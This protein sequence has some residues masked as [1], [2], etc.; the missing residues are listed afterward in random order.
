[1]G[2]RG[3]VLVAAGGVVAVVAAYEI[4]TSYVAYTDDSYVRTDLVAVA[5][6]V[7]GRIVALQVHDNE[8]VKK[9]DLLFSIDP[10]PFR[11]VIAQKQAEIGE[12]MAQVAADGQAIDVAQDRHAAAVSAVGFARDTQRRMATLN[13]S[14]YMARQNLD[15][16]NDTLKRAQDAVSAAE[17]SIAQAR[18]VATMHQATLARAQA[19]M[20]TAQWQLSR[21]EVVSPTD[22]I[23]NNLTI[24]IGDTA[25]INQPLIGI[26]DAHAWRIVAN[27]KQYY[28][29]DL[30]AGERV[31][32]WLDSQPWHLHRGHIASIGR[33]ISRDPETAKLLPYVAPTTDWIRLQR[34]FPVTILLDEPPPDMKFFM[35]ADARTVIFP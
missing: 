6:E 17:A 7:T 34:R 26:L 31:W 10:V 5:P 21:T 12:A 22:G 32:V 2:R 4:L 15:Q 33:G 27:Y 35:G 14:G 24:R 18:S 16:A 20:A 11:L 1:M 19:E 8:P 30:K 3:R 23:V 9:G 29:R 25:T 13:A 28:L